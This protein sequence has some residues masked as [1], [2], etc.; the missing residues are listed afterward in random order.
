ML[1]ATRVALPHSR[2][3][4]GRSTLTPAVPRRRVSQHSITTTTPAPARRRERAVARATG[5]G[6]GGGANNNNT[7]DNDLAYVAKLAVLSFAGAAAIK[8][9]SLLVALPHEPNLAVALAAAVGTPLAYAAW[10]LARR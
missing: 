5:G 1:V 8:Y 6:D 7:D 10:L 4:L 3:A 9:G 2:S